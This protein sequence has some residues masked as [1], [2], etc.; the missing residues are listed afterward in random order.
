MR[1]IE[2]W[3]NGRSCAFVSS[4][5]VS[6]AASAAAE[7]TAIVVD[8]V[9]VVVVLLL[10]ALG[11]TLLLRYQVPFKRTRSCVEFRPR[12]SA[13]YRAPLHVTVTVAPLPLATTD[14]I[15]TLG[16]DPIDSKEDCTLDRQL[17]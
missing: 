13:Q 11:M 9:V 4:R 12:K 1:L 16:N 14:A 7:V 3:S 2:L 15:F 8:V 17:D 10:L 5:L 6:E